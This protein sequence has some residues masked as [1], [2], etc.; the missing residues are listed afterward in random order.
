MVYNKHLIIEYIL[1]T[2]YNQFYGVLISI[3]DVSF[4]TGGGEY[5]TDR[6]VK[7]SVTDRLS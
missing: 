3:F 2:R 5:V 1:Y 4:K 6:F 7:I